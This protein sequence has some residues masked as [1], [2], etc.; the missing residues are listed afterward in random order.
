MYATIP[1]MDLTQLG[2]LLVS[3]HNRTQ[4]EQRVP[5]SNHGTKGYKLTFEP[6]RPFQ[7]WNVLE[8]LE[9]CSVVDKYNQVK[10]KK[11]YSNERLFWDF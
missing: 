3:I 8:E 5:D 11:F 2:R 1:S 10:I 6:N 7:F 4:K 9:D